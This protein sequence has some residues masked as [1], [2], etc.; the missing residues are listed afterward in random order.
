MKQN[1]HTFL[2]G[3]IIGV[4]LLLCMGIL[5]KEH[6]RNKALTASVKQEVLSE[7][8]THTYNDH[9]SNYLFLGVDTSEPVE[10][11]EVQADAGQA[12]S[13]FL[14]SLN[15]KNREIQVLAIPRDTIAEIQVFAPGGKSLGTTKQYLNIQYAF[16]DGKHKSCRLMKDAVSRLLD[17]L[18]IQGYCSLNLDGIPLLADLVD[19]VE[20]TIP[21]DSFENAYPEFQEGSTVTLTSE[22]VEAFVRYRDR[23]T[24]QSALVRQ[25][26]QKLFLQAYL[27][28]AREYQEKEAAFVTEMYETL[29]PY[30]VTNMGTDFFV[31][32]LKA[33]EEREPIAYTLPGEGREGSDGYEE[34]HVDE[35]ALSDLLLQMFYRKD[36]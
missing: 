25:E 5:W 16:G 3:G 15:R 32:L 36:S 1:K 35:K 13:I 17:N 10:T 18:P 34:Y 9:L 6:S 24:S 4:L 22:N 21:D 29:E 20:V 8:E 23:T 31:D 7:E 11:Y 27:E 26:H 2:F 28:K 33:S 30:M 14:V 12:D 19:G